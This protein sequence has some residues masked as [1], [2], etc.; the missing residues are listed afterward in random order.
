M[1]LIRDR[2]SQLVDRFWRKNKNYCW[3]G[4]WSPN[5]ETIH[6]RDRIREHHHIG[7]DVW[8]RRRDPL[9]RQGEETQE[10][11]VKGQ[12]RNVAQGF[13]RRSG[14]HIRSGGKAADPRVGAKPLRRAL[15]WGRRIFPEEWM[16]GPGASYSPSHHSME[17]RQGRRDRNVPRHMLMS[18]KKRECA[19]MPDAGDA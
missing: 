2:R 14:T 9:E 7:R 6:R 11:V 15:R 5:D 8:A 16:L 18:R 3:Q 10:E 17:C 4:K 1:A 12:I 19:N 13:T